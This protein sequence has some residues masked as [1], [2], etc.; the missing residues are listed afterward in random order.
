[1]GN[2]ASTALGRSVEIM[3]GERLI[4]GAVQAV[5]RGDTPQ[6]L[7]NGSFYG[8]DQVTKVFAPQE[9]RDN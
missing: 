6:V 5:T 7:V 2:E 9:E 4:Q 3:D 1:M 8:W